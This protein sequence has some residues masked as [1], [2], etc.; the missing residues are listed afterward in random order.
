MKTLIKSSIAITA[1][2]LLIFIVRTSEGNQPNELNTI[3]KTQHQ[4]VLFESKPYDTIT[5][6]MYK[7]FRKIDSLSNSTGYYY[8]SQ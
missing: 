4:M 2:L 6:E 3:D 8:C 7:S 1:I 5:P